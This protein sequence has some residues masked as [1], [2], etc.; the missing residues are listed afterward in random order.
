MDFEFARPENAETQHTFDNHLEKNL[1]RHPDRQGTPTISFQKHHDIYSLG[2]VLLEIG[3]CMTASRIYQNA[4]ARMKTGVLMNP[5]GIQ[6]LYIDIANRKL[7]HNMGPAYR[8]AV[9]KCLSGSFQ[10]TDTDLTIEF[11]EE[12]VQSIDALKLA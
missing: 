7:P 11:Y 5:R 9:V 2:V 12:V 1:Y 3:L 8:G 6:N 4:T 10:E